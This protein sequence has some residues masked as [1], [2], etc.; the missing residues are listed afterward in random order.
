MHVLICQYHL[1]SCQRLWCLFSEASSPPLCDIKWSVWWFNNHKVGPGPEPSLQITI[2]NLQ[3]YQF[4]F[5]TT[6][7]N[8]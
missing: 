2:N 7:S 4:Q 3:T 5:L 6:D 8:K 1:L